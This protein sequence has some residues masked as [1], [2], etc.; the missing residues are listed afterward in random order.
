VALRQDESSDAFGGDAI[1]LEYTHFTRE[2]LW[3]AEYQDFTPGFRA[4]SGFEPRVDVRRG[5]LFLQRSWWGRGDRWSS[6]DLGVRLERVEDHDGRL[7]DQDVQLHVELEGPMQTAL[8]VAA[9]RTK[10]Y[11]DGKTFDLDEVFF[12]FEAQPTGLFKLRLLG[13][14]G[15]AVDTFNTQKGQLLNLRPGIELKLGR[16]LNLNLSQSYQRL[17]VPGGRLFREN[18]SEARIV[19]HLNVRT[20]ARLILQYRD[21]RRDPDLFQGSVEPES[22][23]LFLQFLASYKLNPH[24]VVFVGYSDDH[25]GF[26]DVSLTQANRTFFAKLGYAWTM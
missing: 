13:I 22:Q 5:E 23:H 26:R 20:F 6:F 12:T 21:V 2:W 3:V 24:T 19:Y 1:S 9:T 4:D 15:D 25:D 8:L 18:L 11:F 14:A 17:D 10:E 7:T 16:H